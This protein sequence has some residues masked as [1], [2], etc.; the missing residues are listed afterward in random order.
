MLS[1][2]FDHPQLSAHYSKIYLTTS[3]FLVAAACALVSMAG[4][5]LLLLRAK[6]SSVYIAII[7]IWLLGPVG[8]MFIVSLPTILFGISDHSANILRYYDILI[9]SV[10]IRGGCTLYL[11]FSRRVKQTYPKKNHDLPEPVN[12]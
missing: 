8:D 5:L 2:H 11:L 7:A 6:R 4:G 9:A 1:A 10:V 12:K 3:I